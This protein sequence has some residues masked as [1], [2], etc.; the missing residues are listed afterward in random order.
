GDSPSPLNAI[1]KPSILAT[2]RSR[3]VLLYGAYTL[4]GFE[5][6]FNGLG[7]SPSLADYLDF[8]GAELDGEVMSTVINQSIETTITALNTIEQPVQIAVSEDNETVTTAY[9]NTLSL[10]RLVKT[11]MANQL[12]ITVTFSDNDGD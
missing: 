3:V 2:S 8:L 1:S 11:D 5:M 4:A 7:E 12:G 6:A 9:N 10:L